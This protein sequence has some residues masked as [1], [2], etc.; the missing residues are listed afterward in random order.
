MNKPAL[1][2]EFAP[3]HELKPAFADDPACEYAI[4][5]REIARMLDEGYVQG[6]MIDYDGNTAGTWSLGA[7]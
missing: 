2:I 1:K 4:I 3:G 6:L 7:G 5:L